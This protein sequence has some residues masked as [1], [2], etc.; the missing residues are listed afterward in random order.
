MDDFLRVSVI[1]WTLFYC[2]CMVVISRLFSYPSWSLSATCMMC[3]ISSL[4]HSIPCSA[5][6]RWYSSTERK[7]SLSLSARWKSSHVSEHGALVC[8]SVADTDFKYCLLPQPYQIGCVFHSSNFTA[9]ENVSNQTQTFVFVSDWLVACR[10]QMLVTSRLGEKK[11]ASSPRDKSIVRLK[12]N[13]GFCLVEKMPLW[14]A[15]TCLEGL[16]QRLPL[17]AVGGL[18]EH[19]VHGSGHPKIVVHSVS[20]PQLDFK[21]RLHVEIFSYLLFFLFLKAQFEPILHKKEAVAKNSSKKE[22]DKIH[23]K[24]LFSSFF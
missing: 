8:S 13:L 5:R 22:A 3:T 15:A 19:Q 14:C 9:Q 17:P 23:E 16:R 21:G 20:S 6:M 24:L 4:E 10:Q 1:L 7:P 2:T 18:L 12:R 11:G